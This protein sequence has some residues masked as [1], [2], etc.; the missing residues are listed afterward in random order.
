MFQVVSNLLD[1]GCPI[2]GVAMK[3]EIDLNYNTTMIDGIKQNIE[4]YFAK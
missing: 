4:R 3:I 2:G 1:A